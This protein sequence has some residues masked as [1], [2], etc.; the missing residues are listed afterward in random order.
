MSGSERVGQEN[1]YT[2]EFYLCDLPV[3]ATFIWN[4]KH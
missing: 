3:N 4:I 1:Q 2:C